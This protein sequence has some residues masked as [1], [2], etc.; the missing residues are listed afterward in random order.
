[1]RFG[2]S[3]AAFAAL[4]ACTVEN[5]AAT[6]AGEQEEA[7]EEAPAEAAATVLTAQG[8]GPLRIGMTLDEVTAAMGGHRNPE[9]SGLPEPELC[10]E[11]QPAR[12]PEGLWVM[13]EEGRLARITLGEGSQVETS[14]GLV[15]GDPSNAVRTAYGERAQSSPHHYSEPPAK[16]LDVWEGGPLPGPYV[17]D[18][19]ARGIRYEIG[20]DGNIQ[21][22]HAGG[23]AIQYV[24]GCL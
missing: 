10:D 13:I 23:P 5:G 7:G 6:Q 21:Y 22:I 12:G 16:Y 15:V 4:A 11:F 18:E 8:Y 3:L 14:E 2:Y 17:E 20:M 24:E 1:M 9:G 19:A